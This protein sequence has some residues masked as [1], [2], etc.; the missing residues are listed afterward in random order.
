MRVG[1]S[2]PD[3]RQ[4]KINSIGK[5][6]RR[7]RNVRIR[8]ARRHRVGDHEL[9]PWPSGVAAFKGTKG[10]PRFESRRAELKN[11]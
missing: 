6:M 8:R 2:T 11:G 9:A 10:V 7:M 3:A 5:V 4:W 1:D